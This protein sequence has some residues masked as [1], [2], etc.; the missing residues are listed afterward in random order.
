MPEKEMSKIWSRN[1]K[2]F[3]MTLIRY[4]ISLL[5]WRR[6]KRLYIYLSCA[7]I[8]LCWSVW[9]SS[10]HRGQE[11]Q[12]IEFAKMADDFDKR[13]RGDAINY[14]IESKG[15]GCVI[16]TLD[17]FDEEAMTYERV[18]PPSVCEETDW[19]DCFMDKCFVTQRIREKLNVSCVYRDLIFVDSSKHHLGHPK[20]L[21]GHQ[22]YILKQSDHVHVTCHDT[23]HRL[24]PPPPSSMNKKTSIP[25]SF[26]NI[27]F[28]SQGVLKWTGL[29]TGLRRLPQRKQTQGSRLNVL[30][31]CFNAISKNGFIRK[32]PKSHAALKKMGAVI[33]NGYN[34]LED[35]PSAAPYPIFTGNLEETRKSF[36]RDLVDEDSFI[37]SQLSRKGYRT[38]FFED[39]AVLSM[40]KNTFSGFEKPPTDHYLLPFLLRAREAC[41]RGSNGYCVGDVPLYGLLL[42]LTFQFS[43]LEGNRFSFT[44]ISDI[45][46][47]EFS[48]RSAADED[49]AWFLRRIQQAGILEDTMLFVMGDH[50]PRLT[51]FRETRQGKYEERLPLMAIVIPER[52]HE[53]RPEDAAALVKNV[54]VLTTPFDIHTTLTDLLLM[55]FRRNRFKVPGADMERGQSLLKPVSCIQNPPR[56]LSKVI[57]LSPLIIWTRDLTELRFRFRYVGTSV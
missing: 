36:T 49:L 56:E 38:A 14:V 44:F 3:L 6:T 13:L 17:P 42:N 41:P 30:M 19:V 23:N 57:L 45:G 21:R 51:P 8:V 7:V 39:T 10:T 20:K 43:K 22:K 12:L 28:G 5:Y 27:A 9:Y 33:L 1:F 2:I 16:P 55:E 26:S 18:L 50:G 52:L 54:D 48:M 11:G 4:S 29:K 25:E 15:S 53:N 40:R 24:S 37:F 46:H 35:L 34:I 47:E 31:L 32:M